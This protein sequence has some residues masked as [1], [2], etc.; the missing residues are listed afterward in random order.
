MCGSPGVDALFLRTVHH[1]GESAQTQAASARTTWQ[2]GG[3]SPTRLMW[4]HAGAWH[5]LLTRER[6][7]APKQQA[8]NHIGNEEQFFTY[9]LQTA[10]QAKWGCLHFCLSG[11][12]LW[13]WA[14]H[15]C[16]MKRNKEERRKLKDSQLH[17]HIDKKIITSFSTFQIHLCP[18]WFHS[19][20]NTRDIHF[21]KSK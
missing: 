6:E 17:D 11:V 7:S 5:D 19:T 20:N 1:S 16:R 21:Q 14:L 3:V 4:W 8:T 10:P 13:R 12:L 9:G 18:K 2:T 15:F